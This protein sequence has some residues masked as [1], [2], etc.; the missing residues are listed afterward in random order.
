MRSQLSS[1]ITVAT[2]ASLWALLSA[3]WFGWDL[4]FLV[5]CAIG[6][7][8][9][10]DSLIRIARERRG[11]SLV[12][13]LLEAMGYAPDGVPDKGRDRARVVLTLACNAKGNPNS[14]SDLLKVLDWDV[15]VQAFGRDTLSP[16]N[17][18]D[19]ENVRLRCKALP[20]HVAEHFLG[21]GW[22]WLPV[23]ADS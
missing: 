15:F 10:I 20:P 2:G 22:S 11:G 16:I 19:I 8:A 18:R 12:D 1:C 5:I 4:T 14:M 13:R 7:P 3:S 9:S 21:D 6:V 23:S 17:G